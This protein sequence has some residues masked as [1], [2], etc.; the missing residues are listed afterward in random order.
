MILDV[1]VRFKEYGLKSVEVVDNGS[2]IAEQ[3][4]DSIGESCAPSY[5]PCNTRVPI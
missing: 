5:I 4:Y 3:D 1:E 2:G